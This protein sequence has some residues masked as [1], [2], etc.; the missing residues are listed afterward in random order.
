MSSKRALVTGG[1]GFLGPHLIRALLERGWQVLAVDDFRTGPRHHLESFSGDPAFEF[2]EGNITNAAFIEAAVSSCAPQ[3]VFHL[4][5]LHFI[6]YCAAHPAETVE[7][8]LLGTQ[9]L[10]DA[11]VRASL[12]SFVLASTGDVYLHS[13]LPHQETDPLGT[14]NIYG[15][16]KLWCEELL[17]LV[18]ARDPDTRYFAARF[19]NLFGPGETNPHVLP[20]ILEGL[21]H[22][23]V[24]RLGNLTPKRDYVYVTDVAEAL[25]RIAAYDGPETIFNVGTGRGSSVSE[26]V[27][28]L[29]EIRNRPIQVQIDPAKVRKVERESL[30]ADTSL[31]RRE[32]GWTPVVSLEEGLRRTL[33]AEAPAFAM[34]HGN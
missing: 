25:M 10:L 21:R 20:V 32:L 26:L 7:V 34:A 16:S 28:T 4:A 11:C 5:A 24:L 3:T 30:V 14:T 2:L 13:H 17:R 18:R 1:A 29:Q 27:E 6:P 33:A 23:N 31:I 9:R 12:E 22:S 8:N 19:F 15:L